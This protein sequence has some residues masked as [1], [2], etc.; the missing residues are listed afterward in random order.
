M[1][2]D[3]KSSRGDIAVQ[4]YLAA[5]EVLAEKRNELRLARLSSF[6]YYGSRVPVDR[7][8]S[9]GEQ[10]NVSN[11]SDGAARLMTLQDLGECSP[12]V[13]PGHTYVLGT[14]YESNAPVYFQVY[15]RNATGTW[16]SWQASPTF[17]ASSGWSHA[18]W[19]PPTIPSDAGALSF[20]LTLASN[21]TLTTDDYSLADS[22]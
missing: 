20:G 13:S 1:K 2:L 16:T 4:A 14:W 8:G 19:T 3:E 5:P 17:P 7:S 11:Y 21:G 18:T 15:Y 12:S 9:F 6:E 10:L 22:A